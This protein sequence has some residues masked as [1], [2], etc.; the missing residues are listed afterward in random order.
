MQSFFEVL[1][2]QVTKFTLYTS[3]FDVLM[4]SAIRFAFLEVM[5]ACVRIQHWW[6]VAISTTVSNIL[7][8]AKIF[9]IFYKPTPSTIPMTIVL[10][11]FS[12]CITWI[13]VWYLDSKVLPEENAVVERMSQIYQQP[14]R[15]QLYD[16]Q[17]AGFHPQF[18]PSAFA[19]A[20]SHY[21]SPAASVVPS[22]C[23]Y[24]QLQGGDGE[25]VLDLHTQEMINQG[26]Y[27]FDRLLMFYN[28]QE[29]WNLEKKKG[30]DCVFS[31][32]DHEYGKT[33][34]LISQ[35]NDY[36][37]QH[38]FEEVIMKGEDM[39]KWNKSVMSVHKVR[40]LSANSSITVETSAPAAMGMIAS[41]QFVTVRYH[42]RPGD[43]ILR[44]KDDMF[45]SAGMSTD[46]WDHQLP[47]N[48]F[49]RGFNGP[50][51]FIVSPGAEVDSSKFVWIL[52]TDLKGNLSRGL[53]N[54]NLVS[55]MFGF[56][57]SMRKYLLEI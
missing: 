16:Y 6:A 7:T 22:E 31:Y 40:S 32:E 24:Q 56:V 11:V 47:Q 13:E 53:V 1:K 14:V 34:M 55:T 49:V 8:F 4:F 9:L 50:T 26:K 33:F 19:A 51:G 5:Y 43:P 21:F 27:A 28:D 42:A 46:K 10:L 3:T 39:P 15:P 57:A 35:I 25:K 2:D 54:S 29:V 38:I 45:V 36:Q 18:Q 44:G 37:P 23:G 48:S 20:S 30:E 41:R 12:F 52:N 17:R